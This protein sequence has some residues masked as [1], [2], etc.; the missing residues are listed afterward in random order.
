MPKNISEASFDDNKQEKELDLDDFD[1]K[2]ST[3]KN[4]SKKKTEKGQSLNDVLSDYNIDPYLFEQSFKDTGILSMATKIF[5]YKRIGYNH[6][7]YFKFFNDGDESL[8]RE[9]FN[10][11]ISKSRVN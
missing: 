6:R 1:K 2:T 7:V 11:V 5:L 10:D 4:K 9:Q 3:K 8:T